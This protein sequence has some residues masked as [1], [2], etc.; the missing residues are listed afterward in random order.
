MKKILNKDGM[1]EVKDRPKGL[2]VLGVV[3]HTVHNRN[4]AML[5][6]FEEY[7][8][9]VEPWRGGFAR[10]QRPFP[11]NCKYVNTF[12]AGHYDFALLH[13]D[14]QSLLMESDGKGVSGDSRAKSKTLD[15]MI[16]MVKR[17]DPDLPI[18]IINHHTPFHDTR[19]THE[20]IERCKKKVGDAYMIC[21]S[22]QA[23]KQWGFGD[24]ITH[25]LHAEEW[26]FDVKRFK[27]TGEYVVPVK[28]PRV[29]IVLSN[30]GM[31]L[32]YRRVF[33]REV[34]KILEE[35]G[36]DWQ[37]I[38]VNKKQFGNFDDYRDYMAKSLVHF[39]PAWQS[40]RPR[41]RTEG[42][43]SGQCIVTTPYHDADTIF[44][45][46]KLVQK[47]DIDKVVEEHIEWNENTNGFLT[48]TAV[49]KDPRMMD[50]PQTTADLIRYLLV[51]RPDIAL[52][53]GKR[54]QQYARDNFNAEG[55]A[56][57]WEK[58]LKDKGI[59]K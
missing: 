41:S 57:Q 3:W 27:L 14:Q 51:E 56:K 29:V 20:V 31:E 17:V 10:S 21:N 32:A 35:Y 18:V 19:P 44:N 22:Y 15:E 38:S 1:I 46:G 11:D 50:N 45:S 16:A 59:W 12:K 43:L 58:F 47:F 24:V 42:Q 28:E 53:V 52:E 2:K 4:L 13:L 55:F 39:F 48:S 25:G 9:M 36:I 49:K 6:F 8:F 34:C 54:G 26:G 7:D 37:W 5:P 33:A 40:P 23:Q 30:G